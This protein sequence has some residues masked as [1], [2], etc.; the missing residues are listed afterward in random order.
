ML[1][2]A[3]PQAEQP[4]VICAAR[5]AFRSLGSP[6]SL[7]FETSILEEGGRVGR[8]EFKGSES[9]SAV[10]TEGRPVIARW[11]TRALEVGAATATG[12]Y[13]ILLHG[14]GDHAGT[15]RL[16]LEELAAAGHRAVALDLPGFGVADP[17]LEGAA[18][19]QLDEFVAAAVESW[20]VDGLAPI[21]VGN[22]LGGVAAIRAAQNPAIGLAGVIPI[23]PASFGHSFLLEVLE[24][25]PWL[26]PV[27]MV[28]IPMPVFRMFTVVGY[29]WVA[30]GKARVLPGVAAEVANTNFRSREDVRRILG[31]AV[32]LLAELRATPRERIT[33]PALILWGRHDRFTLVTGAEVARELAPTAEIVILEDSGHCSQVTEPEVI[34]GH[35]IDFAGALITA[36]AG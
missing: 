35:L 11:Q 16:V 1:W 33:V 23:S 24:R 15:W 19:P 25:N 5:S 4:D 13:F 28:P 26:N 20:T 18:L 6:G 34:A 30:G 36:E 2:S 21:L 14:F 17:L 8:S 32:D 29:N 22:S 7:R 27:A 3:R 10:M 12:P 31:N 9:T